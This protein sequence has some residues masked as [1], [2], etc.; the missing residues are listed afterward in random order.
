VNALAPIRKAAVAAAGATVA[1]LGAAM[2]DGSLT[3]SEIV[4]SIGAGIVFGFA[5]WRVP[6]Q[7]KGA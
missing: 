6:N 4:A 1:G 3:M 2:L 7:K 5:A